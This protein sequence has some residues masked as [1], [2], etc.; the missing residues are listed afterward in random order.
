MKSIVDAAKKNGITAIIAADH[1][2]MNYAKK[3]GMEIHISTQANVSVIS[4]RLSF[5]P[6]MPM[7]LF[8]RAN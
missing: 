8:W 4:I 6:A 7:W 3:V 2:V 5:M 1:A